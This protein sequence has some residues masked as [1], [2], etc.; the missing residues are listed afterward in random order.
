MYQV[1]DLLVF[2]QGVLKMKRD[3]GNC[4]ARPRF[5]TAEKLLDNV[6]CRDKS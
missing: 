1:S 3:N 5:T 2:L 4:N 6:T